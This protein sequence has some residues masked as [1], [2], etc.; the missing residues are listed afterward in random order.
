M[1]DLFATKA[2][3]ISIAQDMTDK[4]NLSCGASLPIGSVVPFMGTTAPQDFLACDGTV[5]NIS[6]YPALAAEFE[7]EYGTKNHFG[8]DGVTTFAVPTLTGAPTGSIF[9]I[10]SQNSPSSGLIDYS[11]SER[12][13]GTWIDGKTIYRKVIDCGNMPNATTKNVPHGVS[14]LD[15]VVDVKAMMKR[16]SGGSDQ[17]PIPKTSISSTDSYKYQCELYVDD[18]NII[19]KAGNDRSNYSA[20]TIML[21]TKTTS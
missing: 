2:D 18:T 5:Y 21:Y 17:S 4:I 12:V 3:L 6:D 15:V 16:T 11:T 8:G 7:S 19:L 13:V 20:F 10:K 1:S 14:N 9:V